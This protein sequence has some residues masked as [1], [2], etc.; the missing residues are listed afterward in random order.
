MAKRIKGYPLT[1]QQEA[2]AVKR[3]WR[4]LGRQVRQS[5]KDTNKPNGK[6]KR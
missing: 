2:K 4:L 3:G 5:V 1:P 6:G